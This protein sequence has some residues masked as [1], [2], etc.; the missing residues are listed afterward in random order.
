MN[1]RWSPTR[2]QNPISCET[3]FEHDLHPT[4]DRA[5]LS[6]I[7][8]G[9]CQRVSGNL[10]RKCYLGKTIGIKLRYD[11]FRTVT[12]DVTFEEATADAEIIRAAARTCLQRVALRSQTTLARDQGRVT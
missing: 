5:A 4:G 2:A 7:L 9:L 11:D 1:A 3:T 6:N 8:L 10:G 12:R